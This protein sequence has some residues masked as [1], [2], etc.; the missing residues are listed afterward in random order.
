MLDRN[1]EG[2]VYAEDIHHMMDCL[3]LDSEEESIK[4][5]IHTAA[6]GGLKTEYTFI[7]IVLHD[8]VITYL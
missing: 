5:F 4:T 1:H 2:R 6:N 8:R 7:Y 3:G